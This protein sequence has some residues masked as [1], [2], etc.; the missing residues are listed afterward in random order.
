MGDDLA[1]TQ[2]LSVRTPMQWSPEPAAGFST[3]SADKLVRPIIDGGPFG[4]KT[5]N[6]AAQQLDPDSQLNRI[7]RL[8]RARKNNPEFGRGRLT[9]L[10]GGDPAVFCHRCETETGAVMAVHNLADHP[11]TADFDHVNTAKGEKLTDLLNEHGGSEEPPGP[12]LDLPPYGY[13]WFRVVGGPWS[14]R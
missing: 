4:Y 7:T 2:R 14:S 9:V 3:A 11:V 12:K 6:V 13:R 1:L 8:V 10:P 5:M